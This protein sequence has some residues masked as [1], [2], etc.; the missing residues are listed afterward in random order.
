MAPQP[1]ETYSDLSTM[2]D[3]QHYIA[4]AGIVAIFLVGVVIILRWED[5]PSIS[6]SQAEGMRRS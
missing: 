3:H 6:V 5:V 2:H 4:L 1:I